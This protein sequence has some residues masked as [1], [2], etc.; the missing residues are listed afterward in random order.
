[1]LATATKTTK[2]LDELQADNAQKNAALAYSFIAEQARRATIKLAELEEERAEL[3]ATA[4]L[5]ETDM[6]SAVDLAFIE[7]MHR[8]RAKKLRA[9][10][11]ERIE[12]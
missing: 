5:A 7:R 6:V 11:V 12:L 9:W 8:D 3:T 4:R 10:A 1:M 2:T